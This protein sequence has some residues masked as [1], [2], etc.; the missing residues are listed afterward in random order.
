MSISNDLKYDA[1][2]DLRDIGGNKIT[3]RA[4]NKMKYAKIS[5]DVNGVI[6]PLIHLLLEILNSEGNLWLV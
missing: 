6:F 2:R 4:L 1:E 5:A 3:V